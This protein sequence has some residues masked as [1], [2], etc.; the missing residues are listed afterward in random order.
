MANT[1]AMCNSFKVELLNGQ[2]NFGVGFVR[3]T[4]ADTIK[5]ALYLTASSTPITSGTTTYLA[6]AGIELGIS[7]NYAAGGNN[8]TNAAVPQLYTNTA[9]WT[10]SASIVWSNLTSSGAFDTVLL[11]NSTN[12]N[13]AIA[14]YGIGSQTITSGTLTLTMPTQGAG[15]ALI[16]IA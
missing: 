8:V 15:T 3:T 10:P 13:R 5:A 6:G 4:A 16:N 7:G 12:S 11:Y 1:P 9:C 2:H 14:S